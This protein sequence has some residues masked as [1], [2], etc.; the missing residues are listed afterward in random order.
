M[1]KNKETIKDIEAKISLLQKRKVSMEE[2]HWRNIEFPKLK[3]KYEGKFFKYFNGYNSEDKWFLYF[4]V[5]EVTN[6]SS[7]FLL[8][9]S[10]QTD[11]NGKIEI[12]LHHLMTDSCIGLEIS[13]ETFEKARAELCEEIYPLTNS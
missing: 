1:L 3:K 2:K 7:R 5:L 11:N 4:Q 12:E 9:N 6:D 13:R 10:F 8:V